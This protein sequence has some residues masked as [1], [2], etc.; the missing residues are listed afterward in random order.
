[1]T[2][3]ARHLDEQTRG[4]LDAY[5]GGELDREG[6]LAGPVGDLLRAP[7]RVRAAIRA[8]MAGDG[9]LDLAIELLWLSD[10]PTPYRDLL[11]ELLLLPGHHHHQAVARALQRL[12]SPASV[13]TI[14]RALG[15]GFD[16]LEY[17]CSEPEVIAKWYSWVLAEIGSDEAIALLREYAASSDPAVAGEMRYR[18]RRLGLA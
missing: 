10:D 12:A 3:D 16:H 1:M 2:T 7:E 8:A 11:E 5:V 15:A 13:D 9:D 18:L 17:T 6:L 14:R 4:D